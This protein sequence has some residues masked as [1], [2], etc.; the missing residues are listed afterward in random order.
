MK[1]LTLHI[2]KVDEWFVVICD[3]YEIVSQART[4]QTALLEWGRMLESHI[5]VAKELGID[6]FEGIEKS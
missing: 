2:E 1:D 3:E 6:P 5:F 4:I